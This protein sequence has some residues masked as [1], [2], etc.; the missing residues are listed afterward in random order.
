[1]FTFF[2]LLSC[3]LLFNKNPYHHHI[4][5]TSA[6]GVSSSVYRMANSVTS[7][8]HLRDINEELTRDNAELEIEV[9]AL[10]SQLREIKAENDS[11]RLPSVLSP[12]TFVLAHAINNSITRPYNYITI[13]KGEQDGIK[14]E[15]GVVDH[16]GVVGIINVVGPNCSRVISLLNPNFRLSCRVKGS[17]SF[18]SLYWDGKSY[19]EAVI[20]ELPKHTVFKQGDTIV[21]SGHSAVFPEGV[22]VGI[23]I[24]KDATA[25]DN[26][27][28]LRVKLITDF[29]KLST[30]RVM[31]NALKDEIDRIEEDSEN[32]VDSKQ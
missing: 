29:S 24:G 4:Y 7:Y 15:M 28:T 20:E 3:V 1:M 8:F 21:T 23:V 25:N 2:V 27:Y 17:D 11:T 16:N 26:F 18:G 10:R 5:M 14:P 12:Y 22:P 31:A 13:N 30:V 9:M 32:E 19:K 6:G